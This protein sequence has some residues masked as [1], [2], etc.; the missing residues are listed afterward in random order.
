MDDTLITAPESEPVSL[1]LMKLHLGIPSSETTWDDIL[2]IFIETSRTVVENCT[3]RAL[4]EQERLLRLDDFPLSDFPIK[5][6][7]NPV[8][9]V[10]SVKYLDTTGTLITLTN[11][12]HYRVDLVTTPSKIYPID[13]WPSTLD[14]EA[15]VRVEYTAGYGDEDSDVPSPIRSAITLIAAH[16]FA[17][18]EAYVNFPGSTMLELPKGFDWLTQMYKVR[19]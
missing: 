17:N 1:N 5:L 19:G 4:I 14:Q 11:D 6:A 8:I 10:D 3:R 7:R 18:R 15:A 13:S 16:Y 12:V 9:S 2:E